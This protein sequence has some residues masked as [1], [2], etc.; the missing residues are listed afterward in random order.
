[1][2]VATCLAGAAL[3][4][5]CSLVHAQKA[6]ED[7]IVHIATDDKAMRAA[8]QRAQATLPEFLVLAANPTAGTGDYRLKVAIS[9]PNGTEHFWVAPFQIVRGGFRGVLDN[10][11]QIVRNVKLGQIIYFKRAQIS[12]W[13]Y[14]R[15]GRQVGSFTV[16]VMMTQVPKAEA[17]GYRRKYGFDC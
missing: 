15:N 2:N 4:A 1:M 13:G 5:A 9:D 6:A 7:H 10:T 12:D 8:I 11:P 14:T 3:A 17:D 16:C